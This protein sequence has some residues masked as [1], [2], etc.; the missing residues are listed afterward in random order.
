MPP[1]HLAEDGG[2][3]QTRLG[4]QVGRNF[5][6]A[7]TYLSKDGGTTRTRLGLLLIE[8]VGLI[9]DLHPNS[10]SI[11][12]SRSQLRLAQLRLG[13]QVDHDFNLNNTR[14]RL[15]TVNIS[16]QRPGLNSTSKQRRFIFSISRN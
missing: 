7:H 13:L 1:T 11:Q 5:N 4:L 6:L 15:R 9:Y 16:L 2:T 8:A 10:Y 3:T 14:I 12:D